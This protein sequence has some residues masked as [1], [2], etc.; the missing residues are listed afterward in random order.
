MIDSGDK[1]RFEECK[2][3]LD[4]LLTDSE[5]KDCAFL[6]MANKQDLPNVMS[7][8]EIRDKLQLHKVKD[9]TCCK[10][11]ALGAYSFTAK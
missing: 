9:R 7:V 11:I 10:H 2:D 3:E 8:E 5:L 4:R 1:E 6:V